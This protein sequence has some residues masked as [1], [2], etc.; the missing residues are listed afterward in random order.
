[1]P[2]VTTATISAMTPVSGIVF[3]VALDIPG[4]APLAPQDRVVPANLIGPD[5]CATFATPVVSGREI[6][7]EDGRDA[8]P[9]AMVND[10][11]ARKYFGGDKTLGRTIRQLGPPG[12]PGIDRRIVGFVEDVPYLTLR[13]ATAPTVFLPV[14]QRPVPL[15]TIVVSVRAA[16]RAETVAAGVLDALR[17]VEPDARL[18]TRTLSDSIASSLVQERLLAV[19]SGWFGVLALF[20]AALG[21]Y[22]V[23]AYH[24]HRRRWE[25]GLRVVL[26]AEP[27]RVR[28]LVMR[29]VAWQL[30]FGM[31]LGVV[32]TF[33]LARIA[34]QF[35]Y[36]IHLNS[37]VPV[38]LSA[39]VVALV[40]AAAGL[41]PAYRASRHQ[42]ATVLRQL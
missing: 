41:M 20:M 12:R 21:V 13:V 24:V 39:A 25:I 26:G 2:G 19:L 28:R 38:V 23:T 18:T 35:L 11:F 15:P 36:E 4:G 14:A 29:N 27:S 34:G 10:A 30:G 6:G 3:Q 5:Y 40:G 31:L 16:R 1:V 9:V 33:W 32:S 37:L 42:P 7:A 8:E 22:G 17:R